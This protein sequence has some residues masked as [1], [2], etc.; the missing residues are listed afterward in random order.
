MKLPFF[1]IKTPT[2]RTLVSFNFLKGMWAIVIILTVCAFLLEWYKTK[3]FP[4]N[5]FDLPIEET[6]SIPDILI[7]FLRKILT[8]ILSI[9][10]FYLVYTVFIKVLIYI[11]Q[12]FEMENMGARLYNYKILI[13]LKRSNLLS[14]GTIREETQQAIRLSKI[15][16]KAIN[17]NNHKWIDNKKFYGIDKRLFKNEISKVIV[18]DFPNTLTK[19]KKDYNDLIEKIK[20]ILARSNNSDE[21]HMEFKVALVQPAFSYIL[22]KVLKECDGEKFCKINTNSLTGPQTIRSSVEIKLNNP[23]H[24]KLVTFIAPLS[25]FI[26]AQ[27]S[28]EDGTESDPRHF[29]VPIISLTSED[30]EL[31]FIEGSTSIPNGKRKLFFYNN[32]TAEEC[33]AVLND[34]LDERFEPQRINDYENYKQLLNGNSIIEDGLKMESGDGIVLWTPLSEYFRE[35]DISDNFFSDFNCLQNYRFNSNKTESKIMLFAEKDLSHYNLEHQ[36]LYKLIIN[37][38]VLKIAI[39]KREL[40]GNKLVS[41]IRTFEVKLN[42]YKYS[43][44]ERNEFLRLFKPK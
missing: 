39:I 25:T 24:N 30:Q 43:Q 28:N 3:I 33:V 31:Y 8:I 5:Y 38:L 29:Y 35:K 37:A 11:F 19:C 15:Y 6:A 2:N 18:T 4:I 21:N 12:T 16:T 27:I 34:T 32:S 1:E 7:I 22:G 44:S 40:E 42:S 26:T 23:T 41:L 10:A 17:D 36:L 13:D 14:E 9:S 20:E